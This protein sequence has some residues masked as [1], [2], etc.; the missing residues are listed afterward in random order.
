[1][2]ARTYTPTA[3]SRQASMPMAMSRELGGGSRVTGG[4][5]SGRG[6]CEQAGWSLHGL[7]ACDC[8]GRGTTSARSSLH[9]LTETSHGILRPMRLPDLPIQ[10]YSRARW[11]GALI[12]VGAAAVI[13]YRL[14]GPIEIDV[15]GRAVDIGGQKQRAL[16]VVLLLSANEPVPR[17]ILADR[18]WGE[19]PPAGAQH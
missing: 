1:M 7:A 4:S 5:R 13:V 6:G 14:L 17:D 15:N 9:D 11:P 19:R 16:L 2:C 18:L 8:L 3:R 12:G 10:A